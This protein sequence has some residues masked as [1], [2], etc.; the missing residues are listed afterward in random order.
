MSV[1]NGLK[2][3][4]LSKRS[5]L[6][7]VLILISALAFA[8]FPSNI[9]TYSYKFITAMFAEGERELLTSEIESFQ[10]RFPGSE[11]LNEISYISAVLKREKGEYRQALNLLDE[12]LKGNSDMELKHKLLL[13]R[14]INLMEL[15]QLPE[16]MSQIDELENLSNEPA[17]LAL[18]MKY[19][20]RMYKK[21]GQYF[22]ALRAYEYI[23]ESCVELKVEYEYLEVLIKLEKEYEAEKLVK[24]IGESHPYFIQS[25]VLWAGYLLENGNM[26]DFD[27]LINSLGKYYSHPQIELLRLRAAVTNEDYALAE[28]IL[29]DSENSN[30][31]LD[32]YSAIVL[33]HKGEYQKADKLLAALS[34]S[35]FAELKVL[36][37]LQSLKMLYETEPLEAI[38]ELKSLLSQGSAEAKAE[39][40]QTMGHFAFRA[41]DYNTALKYLALA[42]MESENRLQLAEIDLLI[43]RSWLM[44]KQSK[45]AMDSFNRYL[46]LYPDG[47]K[48]D[49]ALFSLGFLNFEAKNYR[50]ASTA[51]NEIV[52]RYPKSE[53]LP[54]AKFYLAEIDY[55]QSNYNLSLE[56]YHNILKAEPDNQDAILRVAQN[57][58]YLGLYEDSEAWLHRLPQS[59]NTLILQGHINFIYKEYQDSHDSFFLA[60]QLTKDELKIKEAKS[61]RAL[62]LYQLKRYTEASK[63]YLELYEGKQSPD[64]YL[65]LGAKSAYAAGDY[66]LAYT[67]LERFL[68]EFPQSQHY[69]SALADLASSSFNMGNYEQAVEDYQSILIRY[70]NIIDFSNEDQALLREVFT[71]IELSMMKLDDPILI[72]ELSESIENY[73]SEYIKFELSYIITKLYAA[74]LKWGDVLAQAELLKDQFPQFQ[75]SEVEMLMAQSLIKLN[76]YERADSLLSEI[77]YETKDVEALIAWADVDIL[78][79]D[80]D[81]ALQKIKE[82]LKLAPDS[83]LW[84]KGLETSILAGYQ[85]FVEIWEFSEGFE[86]E[87]PEAD[88]L[89]LSFMVYEGYFEE[90]G[91]LA[92]DLINESLDPYDHAKAFYF[93]GLIYYQQEYYKRAITEF[94]KV[95]LLFA[96]YPDIQNDASYY[97]V[98]S[99]LKLGAKNE[100]M[101]Q[102]WDDAKLL[103]E[104]NIKILSEVIEE[105]QR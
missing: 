100:A 55:Y 80:Y 45:S 85:D 98:L 48:R 88:R 60:E 11:Y 3:F 90:A 40:L 102:M 64:T 66:N 69:L 91:L 53:H 22:S 16:A 37:Y 83:Q 39:Q 21:M 4:Y 87:V 13:E 8:N 35:E 77:Y 62:C 105:Y 29:E 27:A 86:D 20:A 9:E 72:H 1:L 76:E 17:T 61:Y 19:K 50:L 99:Y 42:R 41:K 96:D 31:Y 2:H 23:L 6:F 30:A 93:K 43:A 25:N 58:Y 89:R 73:K 10:S 103:S 101:M 28:S 52:Q 33:I 84:L 24:S 94:K 38:G 95:K 51:F 5:L 32:Y 49:V 36:A 63:L 54:S 68:E 15:N 46:N 12:L 71:G 79:E 7:F 65:Y 74:Q 44:L 81:N 47:R 92:D 34:D 14:A 75:R 56:R 18:A 104:D 26:T 67:L 78:L 70:R 82:A 59:Y 97:T 57:Y